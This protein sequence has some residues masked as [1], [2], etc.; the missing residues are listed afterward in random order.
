M[1]ASKNSSSLWTPAFVLGSV[2]NFLVMVNYYVPMVAFTDYAMDT[3]G[4][5]ASI[6]GLVASIFIVGALCSRIASGVLMAL[7]GARRLLL[8]GLI[9]EVVF[10]CAYLANLNLPLMLTERFAHG[11]SYGVSTTAVAT[12]VT[13]IIPDEHKGEGV[14]YFML[15]STLGT[16]I[17][18]FAG[19]ALLQVSGMTAIFAACIATAALCL[20][21]FMFF[22]AGDASSQ[23]RVSPLR[24]RKEDE[25]RGIRALVEPTALPIAFV[26]GIVFFAYSCA[27][28]F[29][30]PYAQ[31]TGF[32]FASSVF[33]MAYA[34]AAFISRLFTGRLFDRRGALVVMAPSFILAGAAYILAGIAVN[35][36]MLILA[37][38]MLGFGIGTIQSCGLAI[39]VKKADIARLS[40]ANSTYYAF[41]DLGVGVGPIVLG[42]LAPLLGY[43]DL[44]GV[45][46]AVIAVGF[47]LY[48]AIELHGRRVNGR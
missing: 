40:F 45:M 46:S 33:F 21:G 36:A 26:A 43:R 1:T 12:I 47:A 3:Y 38:F 18:P 7:V 23:R 15:S 4:V 29:L 42:A 39:A 24:R 13:G 25:A 14:G 20:V 17:G 34:V 11:F 2:I 16:A 35:D 32:V 41:T 31:E 8:M 10:S 44:F 9:A 37:G 30:S 6:A 5:N 28:T 27:L 19:M 48:L 22:K